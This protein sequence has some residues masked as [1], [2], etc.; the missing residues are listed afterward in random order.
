MTEGMRAFMVYGMDQPGRH[1]SFNKPR[2]PQFS[3]QAVEKLMNIDRVEAGSEITPEE[4]HAANLAGWV[5]ETYQDLIDTTEYLD[6][7]RVKRI[8]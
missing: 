7:S 5:E 6:S 1:V 8:D 4:E 3:S 2:G